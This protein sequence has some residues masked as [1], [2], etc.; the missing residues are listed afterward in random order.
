MGLLS[1]SF[2]MV[3]LLADLGLP[4]HAYQLAIQ[5]P[6]QSAMFEVSWCVGLYVTCS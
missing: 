6:P 4:L 2:V 1:Y 3:T 5:A